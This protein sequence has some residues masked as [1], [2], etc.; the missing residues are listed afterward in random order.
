MCLLYLLSR[1]LQE[2]FTCGIRYYHHSS[3]IDVETCD[4]T[5]VVLN[6]GRNIEIHDPPYTGFSGGPLM[7]YDG[8]IIGIIKEQQGSFS[9]KPNDYY[10]ADVDFT[11]FRAAFADASVG[12]FR[13]RVDSTAVCH[14]LPCPLTSL[15][16][17]AANVT[18]RLLDHMG[19]PC[20]PVVGR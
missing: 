19:T 5:R 18:P 12:N 2:A 11:E 8:T 3:T 14:G 13:L 10:F 16:G 7:A 1:R 15:Y 20:S 9:S 6:R 17:V 4:H